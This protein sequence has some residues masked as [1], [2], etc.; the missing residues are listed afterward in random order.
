MEELASAEI[1]EEANASIINNVNENSKGE[2]EANST[3][4]NESQN[5]EVD[6]EANASS[7][8]QNQDRV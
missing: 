1:Q 3:S 8:N 2:W 7:G 6:R 5:G 4:R